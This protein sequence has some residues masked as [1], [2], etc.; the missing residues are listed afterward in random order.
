MTIIARRPEPAPPADGWLGQL[1]ELADRQPHRPALRHHHQGRWRQWSWRDLRT[2]ADRLSQGL[3]AYRIGPGHTV[4]AQGELEP[5]LL[6]L[7]LSARLL[8]AR[9][10]AVPLNEPPDRIHLLAGGRNVRHVILGAGSAGT[11]LAAPTS[12][13]LFTTRDEEL[14]HRRI[15]PYRLVR[16]GWGGREAHARGV[17]LPGRGGHTVW[18]EEST[19]W[20]AAPD[21]VL[22]YWLDLGVGM[23]LPASLNLALAD[24]RQ[25]RPRVLLLSRH[26]LRVLEDTLRAALP[27]RFSSLAAARLLQRLGLDRVVGVEVLDDAG[28]PLRTSMLPSGARQWLARLGIPLADEQDR[29]QLPAQGADNPLILPLGSL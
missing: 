27:E 25:I 11:W 14:S 12:P 1:H 6:L 21:A 8:G 9:V 16:A 23:T 29:G 18:L 19:D 26:R 10:V 7:A 28:L 17:L 3:R 4:A 22:R 15:V 13:V 2:E 24:R 20:S 5:R